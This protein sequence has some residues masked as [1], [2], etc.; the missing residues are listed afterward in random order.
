MR[1]FFLARATS[2]SPSSTERQSGFSTNTSFPASKASLTASACASAGV[3]IATAR[4]VA[5]LHLL[6]LGRRRNPHGS[7]RRIS[8]HFRIG[9]EH[10][11]RG[12][13]LFERLQ[14]LRIG[15][16]N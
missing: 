2:P 14:P 10:L 12:I 15:V 8:Q 3:A 4:I 1:S 6:R 9:I 16:A 7:Y 13:Q 5:S 11:R